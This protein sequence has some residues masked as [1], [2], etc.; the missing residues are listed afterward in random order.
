MRYNEINATKLF[1]Y[2]PL[3]IVSVGVQVAPNWTGLI[4]LKQARQ[5]LDTFTMLAVAR[6]QILLLHLITCHSHMLKTSSS[7]Q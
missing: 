6:S 1:L 3:C 7:S 4:A 2:L 5:Q